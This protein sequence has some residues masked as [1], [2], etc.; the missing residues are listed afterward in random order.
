MQDAKDQFPDDPYAQ[1]NHVAMV[2]ARQRTAPEAQQAF[3]EGE[4]LAQIKER[5]KTARKLENIPG[6]GRFAI[7]REATGAAIE[8]VPR[9]ASILARVSDAVTGEKAAD[10]ANREAQRFGDA[11]EQAREEDVSPYLSRQF[12]EQLRASFR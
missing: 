8:T 12:G 6:I 3:A 7:T 4:R 11:R 5:N 10:E 1:A 9:M 2:Y